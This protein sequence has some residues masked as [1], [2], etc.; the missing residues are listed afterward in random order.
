MSAAD[1][2]IE[3]AIPSR[4]RERLGRVPKAPAEGWLTVLALATLLVAMAWAVDEPAWIGGNGTRT[5]YLPTM[6]FLGMAIGFAG[7]KVGWGR[8][9]T[10]LVGAMFAAIILPLIAGDLLLGDA[11]S[12]VGPASLGL[13][14]TTAADVAYR[15]WY[16]LAILDLPFTREWGHYVIAIGGLIWGTAQY[17]AYAVFGH[18]RPL[19][20]VIAVGLVL[21]ANMAITTKDQLHLMVLASLG[22]LMLLSRSHAFEEKAT[23]IRRRIGDPSAVTSLYLRGGSAFIAAAI[24]G[25]LTLT[26]TASSKPL[27]SFWE[28][29]PQRVISALDWLRKVLPPGGAGGSGIVSFEGSTRATGVWV[30][31]GDVAFTVD[32]PP[33]E[34]DFRWRAATYSNFVLTGWQW[35]DTQA[36]DRAADSDVLFQTPEDPG[37][38]PGRRQ[39]VVEIHPAGY[40]EA[41]VL[42]PQTVQKVDQPTRIELTTSSRWF[43]ALRFQDVPASYTVT[44]LVPVIGDDEGGLTINRLKAAGE[45]YPASIKSLY[46]GVPAGSL[47]P[48]SQKL[49][50]R[51]QAAVGDKTPYEQAAYLVTLLQDNSEFQYD[52]D[53]REFN[54]DTV[55]MVECF[56][57][58]KRGFCQYYASTMAILLRAMG[59]PTR[60]AGGYLPG[61]RDASGH[62]VVRYS[63]AH[64]WVEVYF[65]DI[66]WVDFDP[67][68]GG[69]SVDDDIP[70]GSPVPSR[71]PGPSLSPLPGFSEGDDVPTRSPGG[72]VGGGGGGTT[73]PGPFIA[74]G[75]LLI[76]SMAGLAYIA[77]RR[78]P[79]RPMEPDVA[80]RGV[81]S[82]ARR[83]GFGPQPAQTVFE[84]AGALAEE[85]PQVRPELQTVARGKV[86][87]AY[88]HRILGD[89]RKRAIAEA[90]RALRVG[91]MRLA[92]RRRRRK[93]KGPR[94]I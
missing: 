65:P 35:S 3:L 24:I 27:Q 57:T 44:A 6:A 15:A 54:C 45:N 23:W 18:R 90:S 79:R 92:F 4:L 66:G 51:V 38:L 75:I 88:G 2:P 82:L 13:R 64:A 22:A 25:S 11:V 87:V 55:S 48:N 71:T 52:D 85:V 47:G 16:D 28:G 17:A 31:N 78:G 41:L 42:S 1:V 53:I 63:G 61:T 46:L 72:N 84:Y 39:V 76:I 19:D 50:E 69:F 74:I 34:Q 58:F 10:H 80:W 33:D 91:L 5:D 12:G 77:W 68:G 83:F 8:W 32:V 30:S 86:E 73:G 60:Y 9:T 40:R 37:R 21:L 67:T 81:L 7:A 14:Y 29:V 70:L 36:G 94:P 89:D 26:A 93:P 62:E 49:L 59:V 43:T 56:A 20:A